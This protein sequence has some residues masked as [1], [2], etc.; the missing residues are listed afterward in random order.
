MLSAKVH[1]R[2]RERTMTYHSS[3]Y[4]LVVEAN[5]RD[6]GDAWVIAEREGVTLGSVLAEA[7]HIGMATVLDKH[8]ARRAA[9]RDTSNG[10]W[11]LPDDWGTVLLT[12]AET[13]LLPDQGWTLDQGL[14]RRVLSDLAR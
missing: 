8:E 4:P 2:P 12:H 10:I 11:M 13:C 6:V 7:L 9:E 5:M 1:S 3:H 14:L